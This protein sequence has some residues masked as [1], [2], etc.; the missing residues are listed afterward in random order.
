MLVRFVRR[1]QLARRVVLTG[2][3]LLLSFPLLAISPARPA[4]AANGPCGEQDRRPGPGKYVGGYKGT[5]VRTF[6]LL[7]GP[8]QVSVPLGGTLEV[9]IDEAGHVVGAAFS[10][11]EPTNT[12][13]GGTSAS[14][15]FQFAL[16]GQ[17]SDPYQGSIVSG[18][19]QA[20]L[21]LTL[22]P[23]YPRQIAGWEGPARIHFRGW[24]RNVCAAVQGTWDME[25]FGGEA[26]AGY[27]LRDA[28][29]AAKLDGFDEN[30]ERQVRGT[31]LALVQMPP[32]DALGIPASLSTD[33]ADALI[34]A[35][36]NKTAELPKEGLFALYATVDASAA[37][38][39]QKYC[40]LDL[41]KTAIAG[42]LQQYVAAGFQ[43]AYEE[44]IRLAYTLK[45]QETVGATLECQAY[46]AGLGGL[47]QLTAG[48]M[49]QSIAAGAP[50][51]RVQRLTRLAILFNWE[52]IAE[53]G[54]QYL[55]AR[56]ATV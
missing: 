14:G 50:V 12:G 44:S 24:E 42:K 11:L 36:W 20:G 22:P 35:L 47:K 40:L 54:R 10:Q 2:L 27:E 8:A 19:G 29:W 52:D 32:Q 1:S 21:S 39:G 26:W 3:A 17:L 30:L 55:G 25:D 33:E 31:V 51:P 45:V 34:D 4:A 38:V 41:I 56:G 28:V 37:V 16:D 53:P 6:N 46:A 7:L 49:Q 48:L 9:T 23:P 15:N 5:L 13:S 43:P 18:Q